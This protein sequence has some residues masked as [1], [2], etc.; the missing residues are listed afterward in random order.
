M[1]AIVGIRQLVVGVARIERVFGWVDWS[2]DG[3]T[4]RSSSLID[5]ERM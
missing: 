1:S 3:L 2:A 5:A 4:N